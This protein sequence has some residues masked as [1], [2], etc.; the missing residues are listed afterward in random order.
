MVHELHALDAKKGRRTL[1]AIQTST[2][3]FIRA[4]GGG[5]SFLVGD[6]RELGPHEQFTMTEA[7][8]S[9]V[10]LQS[11]TGHLWSAPSKGPL[12]TCTGLSSGNWESFQ[13]LKLD[14]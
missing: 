10:I 6:R 9:S 14:R 7:G 4:C 12:V 2:G 5:G 3:E 13:L 1:V 8:G 11:L